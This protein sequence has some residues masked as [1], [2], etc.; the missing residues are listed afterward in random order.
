M[1]P[2]ERTE[3]VNMTNPPGSTP[4][5]AAFTMVHL[6]STAVNPSDGI[7]TRSARTTACHDAN[8]TNGVRHHSQRQKHCTAH[9]R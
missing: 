9:S 1:G 5:V 6:A 2:D 8:E 4:H 7:V 3:R